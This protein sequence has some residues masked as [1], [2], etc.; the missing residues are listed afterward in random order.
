MYVLIK[1]KRDYKYSYLTL[2]TLS[3]RKFSHN[4]KKSLGR[5]ATSS[6]NIVYYFPKYKKL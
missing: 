1:K 6:L 2:K 3:T 5:V 4:F